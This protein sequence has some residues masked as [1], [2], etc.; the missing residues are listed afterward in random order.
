MRSRSGDVGPIPALPATVYTSV[1]GPWGSAMVARVA[2]GWARD[3]LKDPGGVY[4]WAE[5]QDGRSDFKGRGPVYVV[6]APASGSDRRERWAVRHYRRGGAMAMHMGDRYLRGS[7][8]RPFREVD[9][10]AVARARG[11]RTPAVICAAVYPAGIHYRADLVTEVVPDVLTLGARLH[12][13]DGTRDWLVAM[14]RAG[15]LI[16][17]LTEA[18]LFHID[19]NAHNVLL[20]ADAAEAAW[21]VDLDRARILKRRSSSSAD[22]MVARLTRSIVKIGTPTGESL[23]HQE[24]EAALTRSIR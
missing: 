7:R 21:V 13:H 15:E 11:I 12:E 18:R 8:P 22:R 2:E 23:A 1:D 16:E 6:P 10:S 5:K 14:G 4:G 19:L 20:S 17:A 3:A 9:A 24:I